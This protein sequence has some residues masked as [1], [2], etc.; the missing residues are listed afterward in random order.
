[1]VKDCDKVTT[2]SIH[3]RKGDLSEPRELLIGD[4]E[5]SGASTIGLYDKR[6]KS[7][8]EQSADRRG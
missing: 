1:M 3:N 6:D 7:K 5:F 4:K 2:I 8:K